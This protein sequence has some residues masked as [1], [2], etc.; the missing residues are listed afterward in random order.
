M[1]AW[2]RT[3]LLF[4]WIVFSLT[5]AMAL[6]A[7][8]RLYRTANEE[9]TAQ[10]DHALRQAR[11]E[12]TQRVLRSTDDA[13]RS[14][15]KDLA[16]FHVDG[17]AQTMQ[18]WDDANIAV[19]G[20]FRWDPKHGFSA[21]SV[22][23]PAAPSHDSLI[24]LWQ[25]FRAWRAQHPKATRWDGTNP[26]H[27][28]VNCYPT[29]DNPSFPAADL[30]YQS[31]NLEILSYA[32]RPTDP[33]AG[34]AG[35]EDD[36]SASWVFWYQ[37][38]PDDEI[39]GCFFDHHLL[40]QQLRIQ[41]HDTDYARVFLLPA[42]P[43]NHDQR[44]H[45]YS[46]EIAGLP[47]YRL[48]LDHGDLFE[49]KASNARLAVSAAAG[50]FAVFFLGGTALALHTRRQAREAERKVT[51]TTQVSHELRTP[52]TSIRMY[53]D[54]LADP[55][56]T[57]AKRIKFAQT[58]GRESSRLETLVE[59]LL[60]FNSLA[61]SDQTIA[62]RFIDVTLVV[63]EALEQMSGAFAD[64]GLDVQS[65]WGGSVVAKTDYAIVKQAILNLLD[66]A[67]KYA[68]RGNRVSIEIKRSEETILVDIADNGPGIPREVQS[69]LF[70][71]FVQG[72]VT[73]TNKS[74]G[75][76][77][78]LSLARGTLRKVGGDLRLVASSRGAA[79]Q[80]SLP[81]AQST[82]VSST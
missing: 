33:W 46:G 13:R 20:T 19:I 73:L 57:E 82:S 62:C 67:C 65:S 10:S 63:R 42:A 43:T 32:H 60:S 7:I 39:R 66:N 59:R 11:D 14:T 6:A 55:E 24:Q 79:F 22:F 36:V 1:H 53:A 51:F 74:P 18:K 45:D 61:R 2:K 80:I 70:E 76:G 50:L 26:D 29:I 31:E 5:A 54:L 44:A 69:R 52:L 75:V 81:A 47:G 28:Q 72:G 68:G 27:V 9:I 3:Q 56:V 16:S 71:P 40:A 30:G 34:W 78:G 48:Y 4:I 77:L 21:D 38:G 12:F 64:A 41:T 17:L 8:F 37:R 23:P 35:R 58:I 49:R 25:N 15:I